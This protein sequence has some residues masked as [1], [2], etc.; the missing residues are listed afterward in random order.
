MAFADE[1]E[2]IDQIRHELRMEDDTGTCARIVAPERRRAKYGGLPLNF[3]TASSS[4]EEDLDRSDYYDYE[5]PSEEEPARTKEIIEGRLRS[6]TGES[7]DAIGLQSMT[8]NRRNSDELFVT[9]E[10]QP[11]KKHSKRR[12]AVSRFV[13]ESGSSMDNPLFGYAK[14]E[15]V[16]D[17]PA[18]TILV[19][20]PDIGETNEN[21][22]QIQISVQPSTKVGDVIGYCLYRLYTDLDKMP[23]G[24]VD[25]YQL[26]M[27]DDS[28]EIESDLPPLERGRSI[29]ELGF[30]VLALVSKRKSLDGDSKSAH[31][32]VVYLPSGQSFTFE[33]ENLDHSL[34]WLR[35]ESVK[36]KQGQESPQRSGLMRELE[37]ELEDVNVF[38]RPLNLQQSI[39]N[40]GCREFIL[41]R[42]FSSRGEFHPRGA[43]FR[44]RSAA[45]LTPVP[46]TPN[47]PVFDFSNPGVSPATTPCT[48]SGGVS[49][50]VFSDEEEAIM[51]FRV[52]RLH[53]VKRNWPAIMSIRWDLFDIAPVH[54]NRKSFLPNSYQKAISVLWTNLCEVKCMERA[55]GEPMPVLVITWLPMLENALSAEEITLRYIAQN[56]ENRTWKAVTVEFESVEKAQQAREHMADVVRA[57]NSPAFQAYQ[58]SSGGSRNPS[59]AAEAVLMQMADGLLPA[60]MAPSKTSTLRK[61]TKLRKAFTSR[62]N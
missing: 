61:L 50:F 60:S 3:R 31:R 56:Y 1:Q 62:K 38:G 41:V 5:I 53:R 7:V 52:N 8:D 15:A 48:S 20:F 35:D 14:C 28:G 25:D 11:I 42:K 6:R 45:L 43:M 44:Q 51:S 12:S 33:L 34:E 23:S 49:P 59:V 47:S 54:S 30:T 55:T 26:L 29:G 18:K 9:K 36:R 57:L 22:P 27:A 16:G 21:I 17:Q 46:R 37:Y 40:S 19:L 39:G 4:D 13:S 58:H 24:T 2:L 32:I 10:V